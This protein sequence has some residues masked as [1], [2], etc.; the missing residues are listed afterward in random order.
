MYSAVRFTPEEILKLPVGVK[1]AGFSGYDAHTEMVLDQLNEDKTV[2][3]TWWAVAGN[4][5]SYVYLMANKHIPIEK[6]EFGLV[7]P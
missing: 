5:A 7:T 4:S 2:A 6:N 3:L 1:G